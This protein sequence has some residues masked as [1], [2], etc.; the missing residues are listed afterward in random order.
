MGYPKLI[1]WSY[2][3]GKG[4]FSAKKNDKDFINLYY[5]KNAETEEIINKLGYIPLDAFGPNFPFVFVEKE[6]GNTQRAKSYG[7]IKSKYQKLYP[8]LEDKFLGKIP[9]EGENLISL[10]Y[11]EL[12]N[13]ANPLM[14]DYP[15]YFWSSHHIKKEAFNDNKFV[16]DLLNYKPKNN[17]NKYQE[18]VLPEFLKSLKYYDKELFNKL[19]DFDKVKDLNE[20][21]SPIGKT[22]KIHT[23]KPSYVSLV[24]DF[25]PYS[26]KKSY[27]WDGEKITVELEDSNKMNID[28]MFFVPNKDYIVKI[29]EEDSVTSNTEFI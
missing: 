24:N 21:L 23:L 1:S 9:K 7:K 26:L 29:V 13:Y 8:D 28:S 14:R 16:S 15:K 27:F 18:K 3:N 11:T 19:L 6:W 12:P 22:V 25:L 20:S 10:I 4:L 5:V 2:R 17:E